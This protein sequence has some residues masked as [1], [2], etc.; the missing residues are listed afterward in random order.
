M[1]CIL[2]KM[3][4]KV[5]RFNKAIIHSTAATFENNENLPAGGHEPLYIS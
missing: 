4:L 2:L 3:N 5:I 1:G